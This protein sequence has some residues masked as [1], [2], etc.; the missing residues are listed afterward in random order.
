MIQG[1]ATFHM[2]WDRMRVDVQ[3]V[4]PNADCVLVSREMVLLMVDEMNLLRARIDVLEAE[5]DDYKVL[6]ANLH[7]V[8]VDWRD[9]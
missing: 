1:E 8:Q 5:V 7:A 2:D 3:F 9:E 6:Y 4:P